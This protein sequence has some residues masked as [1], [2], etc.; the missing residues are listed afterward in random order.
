VLNVTAV[1]ETPRF[2]NDTLRV[3]GS[4]W[5]LSGIYRKLSGSWLTVSAGTDRALTGIGGALSG[6]QRANQILSNPYGGR[7]GRANTL[8]LNPNAFAIPAL[9]TLGNMGRTSI[10]GLG[11]WSFDIALSR[12]FQVREGQRLEFRAEAYNV[13]NSFRPNNPSAN[14]SQ[15]TFGIIRNASDPRVLQFA[16][17]YLF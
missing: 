8:L 15:S 2:A 4:G 16:L 14:L 7:S 10:E 13:T 1:A 17:K 3:L 11:T 12:I 6:G 5:R 9:G